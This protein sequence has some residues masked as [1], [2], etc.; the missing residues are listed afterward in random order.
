[1]T[2]ERSGVHNIAE[3][4]SALGDQFLVVATIQSEKRWPP[5]ESAA[6]SNSRC[7]MLLHVTMIIYAPHAVKLLAN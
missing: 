6:G 7:T 3:R 1:L 5:E 4:A 2:I